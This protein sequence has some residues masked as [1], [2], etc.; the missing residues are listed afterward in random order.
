MIKFK[1]FKGKKPENELAMR[2]RY[3]VFVDEQMV[4]QELEKDEF[5]AQAWHILALKGKQPVAT[6]RVYADAQNPKIAKLGRVAVLPE[7]RHQG[8]GTGVVKKL[9]EIA[10]ELGCVKI[11]IH[12]QCQVEGMYKKL[13]FNTTG[14]VF[15]EAGI[16]HVPMQLQLK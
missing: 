11:E 8:T 3:R 5:D 6:G 7:H 12:A 2:V 10:K 14:A 4:P 13:G 1:R 15:D 16:E 9:V